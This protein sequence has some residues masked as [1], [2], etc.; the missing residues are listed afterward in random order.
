MSMKNSIDIIG[1][2]IGDLPTC[3]AV[4]QPTAPSRAPALQYYGDEMKEAE[5]NGAFSSYGWIRKAHE[6]HRKNQQDASNRVVE[7]II[8]MFLNCSTCFGRH[9]ARHHELKNCNC[10]LWFYIRVWLPV[11]AMTQPSQRPATINVC[12]TRGCNYSFWAP[13]D[14]RC[15][16]RNMLSN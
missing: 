12:K 13:D 10:S 14:G 3:S 7:F 1:N 5:T 6:S 9:I 2:W 11:A 16:A 15:V 4:P 8:P